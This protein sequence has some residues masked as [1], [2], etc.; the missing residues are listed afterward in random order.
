VQVL[1]QDAIMPLSFSNFM[2]LQR[3]IQARTLNT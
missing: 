1:G 3:P 2:A